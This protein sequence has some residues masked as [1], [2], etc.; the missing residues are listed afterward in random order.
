MNCGK[1]VFLALLQSMEYSDTSRTSCQVR[2]GMGMGM[3]GKKPKGTELPRE[4]GTKAVLG[5][6]GVTLG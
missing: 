6:R 3:N 1:H 5:V 4:A 2:L